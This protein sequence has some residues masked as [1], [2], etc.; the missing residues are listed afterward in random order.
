[1]EKY[2]TEEDVDAVLAWNASP[3]AKKMRDIC[4]INGP[5]QRDFVEAAAKWRYETLEKH[6]DEVKKLLLIV[7]PTP[8]PIPEASAAPVG[9]GGDD[10]LS[11]WEEMNPPDDAA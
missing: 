3:T 4:G 7:E 1:V 9:A 5:V 11:G 2:L 6:Q 10:D 8:A